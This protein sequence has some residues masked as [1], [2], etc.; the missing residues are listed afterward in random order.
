MTVIL[1]GRAST[2]QHL[3]HPRLPVFIS[4]PSRPRNRPHT[5]YPRSEHS[6]LELHSP[7]LHLSNPHI[8]LGALLG[9]GTLDL[10]HDKPV[11]RRYNLVVETPTFRYG[12]SST[13]T[14]TL[15]LHPLMALATP[16]GNTAPVQKSRGTRQNRS[17]FR[18]EIRDD[19]TR[20]ESCL[21]L[22]MTKTTS[23]E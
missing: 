7:D 13:E 23:S 10:F 17:R 14:F 1:S 12:K 9:L 19:C 15:F 16:I 18:R 5:I 20:R 4:F 2:E 22:T 8:I 3:R 6:I 11:E 21:Q